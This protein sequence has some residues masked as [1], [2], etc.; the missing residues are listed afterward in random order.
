MEIKI[1]SQK[2]PHLDP[3]GFHLRNISCRSDVS[4]KTIKLRTPLNGCGTT[5]KETRT[6]ITYENEVRALKISN[7][8][9]GV[10]MTRED[11]LTLRFNCTYQ[12][13]KYVSVTSFDVRRKISAEEAT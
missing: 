12:R 4:G 3:V 6:E 11:D 1:D 5:I 2:Y 10:A 7:P 8:T 13:E 9:P